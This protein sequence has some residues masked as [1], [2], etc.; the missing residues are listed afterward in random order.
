MITIEDYFMG[1]DRTH[2]A[3]LTDEIR[4]NAALTVARV[5]LLLADAAEELIEPGTDEVTGT[6]VAS[7]WRPAGINARTQ[8]AA[9]GSKHLTAQAC[10][11]QDTA[12]RRLAR[13]CLRNLEELERIGL[14]MEDPQWTPDWVHLSTVPPRSGKRVYRPSAAEPLV[15]RLPE[16]VDGGA[17]A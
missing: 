15:A 5:N 9:A 13:W 16:Q 1:R 3:E 8:N 2:A 11:L 14:W 10:D 6:P 7:G 4:A 17:V 12:D